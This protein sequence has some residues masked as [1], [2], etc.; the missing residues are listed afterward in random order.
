MY[1]QYSAGLLQKAFLAVD[2][3]LQAFEVC[4]VDKTT[5]AYARTLQGSDFED[6]LQI[7]CAVHAQLDAIVTRDLTGF[8]ASSIVVYDAS[9][10]L[11]QL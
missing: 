6:N 7:A 4:T 10:M 8:K 9:Q 5:L 1:K 3:C 2:T 11:Q